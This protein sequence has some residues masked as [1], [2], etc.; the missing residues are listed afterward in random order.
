MDPRQ[1]V[2]FRQELNKCSG[3]IPPARHPQGGL[4]CPPPMLIHSC[5]FLNC[6]FCGSCFLTLLR[7]PCLTEGRPYIGSLFVVYPND[8]RGLPLPHPCDGI[9]GQLNRCTLP[10]LFLVLR[11]LSASLGTVFLVTLNTSLAAPHGPGGNLATWSSWAFLSSHCPYLPPPLALGASKYDSVSPV[12][13]LKPL[14]APLTEAWNDE[15]IMT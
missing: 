8:F 12:G 3:S 5:L 4:S 10:S 6:L 2:P 13:E 14:P 11:S 9:R 1:Q 15:D 7:S